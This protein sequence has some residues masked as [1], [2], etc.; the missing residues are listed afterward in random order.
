MTKGTD[1]PPAASASTSVA[2]DGSVTISLAG[3]LD[4]ASVEGLYDALIPAVRASSALTFDV[5][6][7]DF[8][9]SSG[10]ALLLSL[11]RSLGSATVLHAPPIIRR[12]VEVTGL[13]DILQIS[14]D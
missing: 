12:I 11:T 14:D 4:A 6:E 13:S 8:M 2:N 1:E 9:D 7:L 5:A 10:I 3:E